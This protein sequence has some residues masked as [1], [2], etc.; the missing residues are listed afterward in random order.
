MSDVPGG[1]SEVQVLAIPEQLL[2]ENQTAK[3]V[4]LYLE[5]YGEIEVSVRQLEG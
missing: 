5:L 1:Q 4:Y 2:A 3:L